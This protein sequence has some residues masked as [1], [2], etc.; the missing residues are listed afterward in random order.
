MIVQF[1][2]NDA[3]G[4]GVQLYSSIQPPFTKSVANLKSA[5][6][7]L[8][9]TPFVQV[10]FLFGPLTLVDLDS[11]EGIMTVNGV[12]LMVWN[13]PRLSWNTS[14]T[15]GLNQLSADSSWIYTPDIVLENTASDFAS[16]LS[17][18]FASI[19]NDGNVTWSRQGT[20]SVYCDIDV[21][22]FPFDRQTCGFA[23][24]STLYS[25]KNMQIT[26]I[27]YLDPPPLRGSVSYGVTEVKSFTYSQTS[28]NGLS[29]YVQY[30]ISVERFYATYVAMSIMPTHSCYEHY[31]STID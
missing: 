24:H 18:I 29:S 5:Q 21:K 22:M 2:G 14:K 9:M 27:T 1:T 8:T 16:S 31:A 12:V 10:S 26:E 7:M 3:G 11:V 19:A 6:E 20:L 25:S 28:Q 30:M 15:L 17:N 23:F 4:G 13:D